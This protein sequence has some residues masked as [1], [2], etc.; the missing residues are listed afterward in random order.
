M[1]YVRRKKQIKRQFYFCV[2]FFEK[3][4]FKPVKTVRELFIGNQYLNT[5]EIVRKKETHSKIFFFIFILKQL[6]CIIIFG[7]FIFNSDL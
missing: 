3:D 6:V 5:V 4:N 1:L 7:Y 2:F